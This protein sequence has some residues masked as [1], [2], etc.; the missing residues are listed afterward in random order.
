M[1]FPYKI[2]AVTIEEILQAV[3]NKIPNFVGAK[4]T[5]TNL[6]DFGRCQAF[7]KGR[8]QVMNAKDEVQIGFF[9]FYSMIKGTRA[10]GNP[11][12]TTEIPHYVQQQKNAPKK[13]D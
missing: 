9:F 11:H 1:Q 7:E 3:G 4:F 10:V 2:W 13:K 12:S 5:D 6:Y 8:F